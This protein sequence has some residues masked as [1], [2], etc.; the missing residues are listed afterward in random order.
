[1]TDRRITKS[2]QAIEETFFE[3]LK[4]KKSL[5]KITVSEITRSAN[6]GRGYC[7]LLYLNLLNFIPLNFV[8][9]KVKVK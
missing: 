8:R 1:M 7:L 4:E 9:F 5:N 3:L 2:K 6:L